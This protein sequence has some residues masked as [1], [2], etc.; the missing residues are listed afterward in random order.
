MW[1]YREGIHRVD[2]IRQLPPSMY[3]DVLFD[4]CTEFFHKSFLFRDLEE[5][6]RRAVSQIV[7]VAIYNP[8]MIICRQGDTPSAMYYIIQGECMVKSKFSA[9]IITAILRPGCIFGESN[10]FFPHPHDVSIETRTCCQFL[11]IKRNK[12]LDVLAD[13]KPTWSIMRGRLHVC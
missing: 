10:L 13:F 9:N 3:E 2:I 11:I 1:N 6:F 7:E 12:L 5:A 8:D 4:I